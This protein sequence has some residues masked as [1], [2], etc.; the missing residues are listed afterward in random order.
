MKLN[1]RQLQKK[2]MPNIPGNGLVIYYIAIEQFTT[3]FHEKNSCFLL[4]V[5]LLLGRSGS[6]NDKVEK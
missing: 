6:P 1:L 2:G 3:K 4:N 5:S